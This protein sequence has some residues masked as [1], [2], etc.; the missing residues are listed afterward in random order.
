MDDVAG[1]PGGAAHGDHGPDGGQLHARGPR[2][3]ERGVQVRVT[4]AVVRMGPALVMT[5]NQ[6]KYH[7]VYP[8]KCKRFQPDPDI[9]NCG[10]RLSMPGPA[11]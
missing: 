2:L 4:A 6:S 10:N 1:E 8:H 5:L 7:P 9:D 3:Q 11:V